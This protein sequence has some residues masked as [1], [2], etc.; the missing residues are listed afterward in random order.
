MSRTETNRNRLALVRLIQVYP[1]MTRKMDLKYALG[2][3]DS[4]LLNLIFDIGGLAEQDGK[5][6]FCTLGDKERAERKYRKLLA[7]SRKKDNG[8]AL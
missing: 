3:N 2:I 1:K 8:G 4:I 5:L 7:E 6:C